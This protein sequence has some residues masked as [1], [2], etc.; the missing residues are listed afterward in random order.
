MDKWVMY[1]AQKAKEYQ[2]NVDNR[3]GAGDNELELT[4]QLI[5]L[6]Q[7]LATADA[8]RDD[9]SKKVQDLQAKNNDYRH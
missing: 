8:D 1:F 3:S 4:N 9:L 2:A 6:E 7:K 5:D